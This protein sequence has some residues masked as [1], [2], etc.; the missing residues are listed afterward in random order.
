MTVTR[1]GDIWLLGEHR[2]MCGDATDWADVERLMDGERADLVLT[3]PP[4]GS[5]MMG[6]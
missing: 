1:R 2:L 5:F 6:C 4:Y 3:D